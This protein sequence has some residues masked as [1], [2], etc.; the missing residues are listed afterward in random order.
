MYFV[1]FFLRLVRKVV[2]LL[3]CGGHLLLQLLGGT[4]GLEALLHS[5]PQRLL[6]LRSACLLL[7]D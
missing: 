7:F 1:P 2:D 6:R 3:D 4:L 5:I